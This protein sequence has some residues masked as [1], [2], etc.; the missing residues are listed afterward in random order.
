MPPMLEGDRIPKVISPA[1]HAAAVAARRR[2]ALIDL[3]VPPLAFAFLLSIKESHFAFVWT[4]HDL[5]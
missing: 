2:R 4:Q 3:G 5:G 1:R